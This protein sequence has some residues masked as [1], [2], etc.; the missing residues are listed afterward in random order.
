MTS[1]GYLLI[2]ISYAF[3]T[4]R[5]LLEGQV[6][7]H[8]VGGSLALFL[9]LIM[10]LISFSLSY[11]ADFFHIPKYKS[12]AVIDRWSPLWIGIIILAWVGITYW[13]GTWQGACITGAVIMGVALSIW[14]YF[15]IN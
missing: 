7:A 14:S 1:G 5:P 15:I 3:L 2:V 4:N 11:G 6:K 8:L 10:V 12:S 9:T 13:F